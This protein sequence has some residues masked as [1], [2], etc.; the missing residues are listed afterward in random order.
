MK[1]LKKV[2]LLILFMM[3]G[4]ARDVTA[5]KYTFENM[6]GKTLT[7]GFTGYPSDTFILYAGS[8][9]EFSNPNCI[10][11]LKEEFSNRIAT[12]PVKVV[13]RKTW[14]RL[15]HSTYMTFHGFDPED[16]MPDVFYA[17]QDFDRDMEGIAKTVETKEGN[18]CGDKEVIFGK[19]ENKVYAIISN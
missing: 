17:K 15:K 8:K 7:L 16:K 18:I 14:Q 9:K 19:Y 4:F 2:V 10:A 6:S 13:D 12:L 5:F 11:T 1:R 3:M